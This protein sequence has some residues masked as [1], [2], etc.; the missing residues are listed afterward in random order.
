MFSVLGSTWFPTT[1]HKL[2]L[3]MITC[4]PLRPEAITL[5]VTS[6]VFELKGSGVKRTSPTCAPLSRST[7]LSVSLPLLATYSVTPS[8]PTASEWGSCPTLIGAM[9]FFARMSNTSTRFSPELAIYSRCR[10]V[11]VI[12]SNNPSLLDEFSGRGITPARASLSWL[13]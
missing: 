10:T 11:S 1:L 4:G 12:I 5:G 6:A 2:P 8:V 3:L 13:F 9:N 7:M